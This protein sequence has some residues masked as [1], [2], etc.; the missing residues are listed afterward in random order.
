LYTRASAPTTSSRRCPAWAFPSPLEELFL[1]DHVFCQLFPRLTCGFFA[2]SRATKFPPC[3]PYVDSF[4]SFDDA[5]L[6]GVIRGVCLFCFFSRSPCVSAHASDF[7]LSPQGD[8]FPSF[9]F[10]FDAI[11]VM[12][13]LAPPSIAL[14]FM[15]PR[16]EGNVRP[17][18]ALPELPPS[19]SQ[20]L[21]W[22]PESGSRRRASSA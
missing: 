14:P 9:P 20:F 17:V 19:S 4:P 13:S 2:P 6:S 8:E 11:T 1:W 15:P 12:P 16:A 22:I 10:L 7:Y 5:R 21:A 3:S 18:A